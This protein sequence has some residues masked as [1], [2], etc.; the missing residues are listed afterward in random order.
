M[1]KKQC[2]YNFYTCSNLIKE[3]HVKSF[4]DTCEEGQNYEHKDNFKTILFNIIMKKKLIEIPKELFDKIEV[5][6]KRNVRSV[7]KE[8]IFL[9]Q[10]S[11]DSK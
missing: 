9:L 11:T 7:N 3:L 6:A 1:K 5:S 8:I 4:C 10:S 2:K